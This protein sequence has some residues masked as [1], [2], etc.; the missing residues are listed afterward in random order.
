[1]PVSHPES[2]KHNLVLQLGHFLRG[3]LEPAMQ[4]V[5]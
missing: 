5:G 1:L 3:D 2:A 4:V